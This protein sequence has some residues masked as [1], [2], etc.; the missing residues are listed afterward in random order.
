[1]TTTASFQIC[2]QTRG[3]RH[4]YFVRFAPGGGHWSGKVID[5]K[6]MC[7]AHASVSM[8]Y[9]CCCIVCIVLYCIVPPSAPADGAK[10]V[11]S[12]MY[13]VHVV[14]GFHA[15]TLLLYRDICM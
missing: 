11:M 9:I 3:P 10:T 4:Y 15:G 8:L 5:A 1:M 12:Y 6:S 13:S 7:M 14:R 2:S